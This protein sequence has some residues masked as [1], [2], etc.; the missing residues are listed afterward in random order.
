MGL[1][2]W[3]S[4]S[5]SMPTK[6]CME[7]AKCECLPKVKTQVFRSSGPMVLISYKL[8]SNFQAPRLAFADF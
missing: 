4:K 8:L 2:N 1:D 6:V 3:V 7:I 5:T